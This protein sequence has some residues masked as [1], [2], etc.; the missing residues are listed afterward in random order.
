MAYVVADPCIGTKDRACVEVCPVACFYE[1]EDQLFIH[2]EECIDCNA[3]VPVCPV[4]AIFAEA[5]VPE[6]WKSYTQKAIDYFAENTGVPAAKS[7]AEVGSGGI[8]AGSTHWAW[9]GQPAV[10]AKVP[11]A[12]ATGAVKAEAP[13]P[14]TPSAVAATAATLEAPAPAPAMV[15]AAVA[16]A[17]EA[18]TAPAPA[19][20]APAKPAPKPAAAAAPPAKPMDPGE[21]RRLQALLYQVVEMLG[22]SRPFDIAVFSEAEEA[23]RRLKKEVAVEFG[24]DV[25]V[26]SEL[27]KKGMTLRQKHDLAQGL[28]QAADRARFIP[29]FRVRRQRFMQLAAGGAVTGLISVVSGLLSLQ[30]IRIDTLLT[31]PKPSLGEL[32]G[33]FLNAESFIPFLGFQTIAGLMGIFT[34]YAIYQCWQVGK[35]LH[36]LK[37]TMRAQHIDPRMIARLA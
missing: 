26:V 13:P 23:G 18:P 4:T 24:K 29:R 35:Q 36:E 34:L 19:A 15:H 14:S 2:P 25:Y 28:L 16:A 6:Q 12:V 37:R 5:D 20:A 1:N 30:T 11:A 32:L 8:A 21:Y 31:N 33:G 10:A 22:G 3:C 17:T 27:E 9:K 7:K